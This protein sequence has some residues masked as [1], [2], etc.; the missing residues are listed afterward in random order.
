MTRLP[1]DAI[2]V[3][4]AGT[5]AG[6]PDLVLLDLRLQASADT[7]AGALTAVEQATRTM[8]D[9]ARAGEGLRSSQTLSLGV[10]QRT[11]EQGPSATGFTAYGQV[12]LEVLGAEQV[13]ELIPG[14]ATAVGDALAIDNLSL[15]VADPEPLLRQARDA[16]FADARSRA[17]QY[18]ALA[19]RSLGHVLAVVDSP[20]SGPGPVGRG[21]RAEMASM[22]V[23]AGQ[24]TVGASVTVRWALGVA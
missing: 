3:T 4:G 13:G 16:A 12:R 17:E 6:T 10:R 5:A 22:P 15:G 23:E 14:L 18:A 19:G 8:L 21:V 1:D 11:D 24:H 9:S 2:E 7:V 20:P